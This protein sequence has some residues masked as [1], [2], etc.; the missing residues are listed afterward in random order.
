MDYIPE[1]ATDTKHLQAGEQNINA[2]LCMV[3]QWRMNDNTCRLP[4]NM[5]E[6]RKEPNRHQTQKRH[7]IHQWLG[8]NFRTR[9]AATGG[10]ALI[11]RSRLAPY[12]LIPGFIFIQNFD[13][14]VGGDAR[15]YEVIPRRNNFVDF[16]ISIAERTTIGW[17]HGNNVLCTWRICTG[18]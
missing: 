8:Y 10:A 2:W 14:L 6:R 17:W 9:C 13:L 18:H 5:Q 11:Q 3:G 12:Q 15:V 4:H 7:H 16:I 1:G